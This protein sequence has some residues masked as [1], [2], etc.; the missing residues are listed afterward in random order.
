MTVVGKFLSGVR[1]RQSTP[2][3]W[4]TDD[5]MFFG[6]DGKCWLY[7][8][9]PTKP[10]YWEDSKVRMEHAAI[11]HQ[12][13]IE[14]GALSR[15]GTLPGTKMG[16]VYRD[17]HLVSLLWDE[18]PTAPPATPPKVV[19]WLD[20]VFAEFSVTK[21]LFAIGVQLRQ[22]SALTKTGLVG[23]LRNAI[24]ETMVQPPDR[25]VYQVDRARVGQ[26][27]DRAGGCPPTN[28]EAIRLESWWNGGRGANSSVIAEPDGTS[29][30]C[31]AWPEGL[32]FS[33]LL[34]FHE[35]QLFP[36]RGL[37]LAD[38]FGH[39]E[40]CVVVSCR[41]HLV[42]PSVARTDFRKAQRKGKRRIQEQDA[43]GDLTR[44]EDHQLY[45]TSQLL[46]SLFVDTQEPLIRGCSVVFARRANSST[47]TYA[48]M[49]GT[50]W[51]LDVKTLEYRQVDALVETLPLGKLRFGAR[52]PFS[53]D[54]TVGMLAASGIGSHNKVGDDNG[55]WIGTTP[56]DGTLVWLDPMGASKLH[57]PP[58]LGV[59]GEPGAGKT[60]F[61]QL[62]ATQAKLANHSV[63]FINPKSADSLVEFA[64][65]VDGEVVTVSSL[66][67][68]PGLLDPFR[69]ATPDVAVEMALAHINTVM[70]SFSE[71]DRVYLSSGLRE[72]AVD[73]ALCVGDALK[74]P[75]V[76]P[77]VSDLILRQ[78]ANMSLFG[79]GISPVPRPPMNMSAEGQ[80]T[81]VE[82]DR[83]IAIP[84]SFGPTAQFDLN[85]RCGIAAIRLICRA[86]LE[87]MFNSGGGVLIVDEAHVFLSSQE[88]RSIMQGLGRTG[89][90]QG[91]LPI[92][93]TQMLA[94]L[95]AEG[96]DMESY[97]G[98]VLIMHME[99][100]REVE[101]ALR[102]CGLDDTPA[103]RKFLAEAG[104]VTVPGDPDASHGALGYYRDLRR[105]VSAVQIGPVTEP[106]RM[107][108]STGYEDRE[109]K[110]RIKEEAEEARRLRGGS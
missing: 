66:E 78:A 108:F 77:K 79:L 59:V 97:M 83:P 90:S 47:N 110:R 65:A 2:V 96:V 30:S 34:G 37:W 71:E 68:E 11:L 48:T 57:K 53:H 89:R 92:M 19:E 33:A 76:P 7:Y 6:H 8:I 86:A 24:N 61:L 3:A 22:A 74:H 45:E 98:R 105:R 102:L 67:A 104:P 13:F 4:R 69:Y 21:S 62:V 12:M 23:T 5:G 36:E 58:T 73:G 20:D 38:A 81:L 56:P 84:A 60:F 94:D 40:G 75:T 42:P 88:G 46:E 44:E 51:G 55:V 15:G 101:A 100:P 29:I 63:V 17:F 52:G 14:L 49:L 26:I 72:A 39:K 43:T 80:L 32:E 82:F 25:K 103:R 95:V 16:A 31:N 50:H 70:V 28:A 93:A 107:R 27:L 54:I 9:L 1:G 109:T 91:I 10:L 18:Y 106:I 64:E 41:G 85:E 99:A 35:A 87:Q